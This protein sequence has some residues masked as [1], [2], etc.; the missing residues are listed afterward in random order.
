MKNS[1]KLI[2]TA[3]L[4]SLVLTNTAQAQSHKPVVGV[5]IPQQSIAS[6]NITSGKGE[7]QYFMP[8]WRAYERGKVKAATANVEVFYVLPN[9]QKC[10]IYKGPV[11]GHKYFKTSNTCIQPGAALCVKPLGWPLIAEQRVSSQNGGM[12]TDEIYARYKR[13]E[14]RSKSTAHGVIAIKPAGF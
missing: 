6:D 7:D 11:K 1:I 10:P 9:G 14:M 5:F 8:L 2:A 4:T 3:V 12:C 13:G